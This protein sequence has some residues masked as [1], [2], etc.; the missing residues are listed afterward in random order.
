MSKSRKKSSSGPP[1]AATGASPSQHAVGQDAMAWWVD[2]WQRSVLFWDVL[3]KR[4]NAYVEHERE[5]KPPVLVFE[6]EVVIDGSKLKRPVNYSLV[7]IQPPQA[8]KTDPNKRPLVVIDPRA[9][10][11]PGLGG[12]KPDSEI[13]V[14]LRQGHPCYFITFGPEPMP[15]Q[16]IADIVAAETEFL[17]EVAR[18]HP[19][20]DGKPIVIGNCQG[21]WALMLLSATAPDAVGPV[22]IAGSPL[23]YWAGTVGKHPMR[24]AGGLMGGSWL[25][26]FASDLGHGRF[27]GASLVENFENLNPANTLWGKLYNLYSKIDTEEPRFLEFERWWGGFFLMN[28]EE[29][30]WIVQNLFVGNKLARGEARLTPDSPPLDLRK[31]T[32]PI[33]VF[34]SFGD[35]ITPPPQALNWIL[36]LY[37]SVDEIR[38]YEQTI[39]YCLHETI[40]H[41]GIFV[42]GKVANKETHELVS[43]LDLVD[44]LPPGLYE[45]VIEPLDA[46]H[47]NRHLVEGGHVIRFE[48]RTLDDIR[49]LDDGREDEVDFESVRRASEI[50]Q[51]LYDTFMSPWIKAW[52]NEPMAK[53]LRN[54]SPSRLQRYALSDANPAMWSLKSAAEAVRKARV[55]IDDANAFRQLEQ[56]GSE[57]IEQGLDR[58][59]DARDAAQEQLFRKLYGSDWM[60]SALGLPRERTPARANRGEAEARKA[61][62]LREVAD[63][64][65]Q[66]G[67]LEG[68][69][70][71]AIYSGRGSAVDE[72][73]YRLLRQMIAGLPP[74]ARPTMQE[75]K[76]ALRHQF[77]ALLYDE[78]RALAALPKLLPQR[79]NRAR[80]VAAVRE[81]WEAGGPLSAERKERLA[82]VERILGLAG[83]ARAAKKGAAARRGRKPVPQAPRAAPK[84]RRRIAA[85]R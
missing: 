4:G 58:Y 34:A 54:L 80:V 12:S 8:H 59:R 28:K 11:G 38:A 83:G 5:G 66:G 16:T 62:K 36:D 74:A 73:P 2:S 17:R 10:H 15:G 44:L 13:G 72:R 21:G 25:A 1:P 50:N 14:A 51:S 41:L 7:H 20:A 27:D 37:D 75:V 26:S 39:V 82:R 46:K 85:R 45:A 23:S 56:Q 60:R 31:I 48:P 64:V 30:E 24:Y 43:T 78:E 29:I 57:R 55:P 84:R 49:K 65:E 18:R 32:A 69:A 52:S 77:L 61:L 33:V 70:R 47:D 9:G 68:W 35:N 79:D 63:T 3:R 67:L 76:K 40:G 6:W 53:A 42:S 81:M 22:L 71:V 19:N